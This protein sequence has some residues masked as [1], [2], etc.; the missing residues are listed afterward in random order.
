MPPSLPSPLHPAFTFPTITFPPYSVLVSLPTQFWFP[1]SLSFNF[2]PHS[3]L[4]SLLTQFWFP[5]SLSFYHTLHCF[6]TSLL[7]LFHFHFHFSLP[8]IP[9]FPW[10]S[11][12][13]KRVIEF[14]IPL[15][16]FSSFLFSSLLFSSLLYS[17]FCSSWSLRSPLFVACAMNRE[18]CAEYL[19]GCLDE[20]ETS[21]LISDKRGKWTRTVF[22]F[23]YSRQSVLCVVWCSQVQHRALEMP[24]LRSSRFIAPSSMLSF[25]YSGLLNL[26]HCWLSPFLKQA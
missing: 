9:H 20:T 8:W 1:S 23:L 11:Y 25:H 21:L 15:L 26:L 10:L 12:C 14:F 13:T 3:V 7:L 5:S 4:I 6:T 24:S 17:S 18:T 22:E 16:C 2:P 19:I